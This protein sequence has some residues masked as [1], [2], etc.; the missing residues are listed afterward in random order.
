MFSMQSS[1][2]IIQVRFGTQIPLQGVIEASPAVPRGIKD[3][4]K[5]QTLLLTGKHNPEDLQSL[6][7]LLAASR[8]RCCGGSRLCRSEGTGH[9]CTDTGGGHI[10]LAQA[11]GDAG[12]PG[13]PGHDGPG[14][15]GVTVTPMSRDTTGHPC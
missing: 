2:I 10:A 1:R 13:E 15:R 11:R 12:Y 5:H 6:W 4:Q 3:G 9:P 7:V 8:G 14:P